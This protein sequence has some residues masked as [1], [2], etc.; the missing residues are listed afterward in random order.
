MDTRQEKIIIICFSSL[1]LES[2]NCSG[3][4]ALGRSSLDSVPLMSN[5]KRVPYSLTATFAFWIDNSGVAKTAL[6]SM[7]QFG[8]LP[9][10]EPFDATSDLQNASKRWKARA[11]RFE[12]LK[13]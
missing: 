10:L 2:E 6:R 9:P 1:R 8:S 7:P 5:K 13:N 12:D 4:L 3:H 11:E